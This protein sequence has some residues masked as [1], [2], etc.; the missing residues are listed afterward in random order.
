MAYTSSNAQ[1]DAFGHI[2]DPEMNKNVPI[3]TAVGQQII[4]NYLE[5]LK[6]GPESENIVSTKMFYKP[7][8]S[9]RKSKQSGG[10]GKVR[11]SCGLCNKNVYSTQERVKLS[12]EYF[13]EKCFKESEN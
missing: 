13:H 5:C 7:S 12:G 9:L 11:G 3:N 8:K 4:K 6:N 1:S 2:Y 10:K